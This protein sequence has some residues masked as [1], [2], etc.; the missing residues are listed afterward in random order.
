M[1][2]LP[3]LLCIW[4]GSFIVSENESIALPCNFTWLV[5]PIHQK[6]MFL[7]SINS[8]HILEIHEMNIANVGHYYCMNNNQCKAVDII[9]L[10]CNNTLHMPYY[11]MGAYMNG[12]N[13]SVQYS[14]YVF[15][16]IVAVYM[17]GIY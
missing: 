11:Y 1:H 5:P 16:V 9:L 12:I 8:T 6:N 3:L 7:H 14:N 10:D 4:Q 2:L 17:S 15:P 13:F